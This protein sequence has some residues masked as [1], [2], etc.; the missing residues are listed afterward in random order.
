MTEEKLI[1]FSF[2]NLDYD[3]TLKLIY[4][5]VKSG[6]RAK[7]K[8]RTFTDKMYFY[9]DFIDLVEKRKEIHEI[10]SDEKTELL[11]IVPLNN[12]YLYHFCCTGQI[13]VIDH[14]VKNL[15]EKEREE[16]V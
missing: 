14:T 1:L 6:Q 10:V 3:L 16:F 12:R 5:F 7:S 4:K 8:D 2:L 11:G 9:Q 13:K 15:N